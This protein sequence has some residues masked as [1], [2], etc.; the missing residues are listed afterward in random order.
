MLVSGR[1]PPAA[2]LVICEG[3]VSVREKTKR[4]RDEVISGKS[5]VGLTDVD[6]LHSP[7]LFVRVAPAQRAHRFTG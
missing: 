1:E 2:A 5:G 3:S 6:G 7:V 4:N